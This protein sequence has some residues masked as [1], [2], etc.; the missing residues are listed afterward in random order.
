MYPLGPFFIDLF[1]DNGLVNIEPV[2]MKPT[3]R[4]GRF[5]IEGIGRRLDRFYMLEDLVS[6]VN[7]FRSLIWIYV[8][9]K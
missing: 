8:R 6:L 3:W 4:N 5:G 7:R 9:M 1:R 2:D